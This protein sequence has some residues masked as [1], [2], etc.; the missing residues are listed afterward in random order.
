VIS[1]VADLVERGELEFQ[2]EW[3][4]EEKRA[5]IE[6]ACAQFGVERLGPIKDGLPAEVTFEEIR[7]VVARL[8]RRASAVSGSI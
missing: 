7:L 1:A 2:P 5:Q 3:L 6:A 8:R 4:S